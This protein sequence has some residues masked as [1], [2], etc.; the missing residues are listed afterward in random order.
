MPSADSKNLREFLLGSQDRRAESQSP[1]PAAGSCA[2]H[3][4]L[5]GQSGFCSS[6][7]AAPREGLTLLP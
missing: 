2:G 4:V 1:G 3:R 6:F 7:P 5:G